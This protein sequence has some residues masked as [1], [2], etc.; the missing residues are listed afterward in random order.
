MPFLTPIDSNVTTAPTKANLPAVT[1]TPPF[2]LAFDSGYLK[3]GQ[4]YHIQFGMVK[5]YLYLFTCTI[6]CTYTRMPHEHIERRTCP[7]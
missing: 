7:Q 4:T 5:I 2:T 1:L 6:I 3:P